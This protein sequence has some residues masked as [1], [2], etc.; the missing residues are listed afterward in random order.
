MG[1]NQNTISNAAFIEAFENGMTLRE[2][3]AHFHISLSTVQNYT[4][5]LGLKGQRKMGFQPSNFDTEL[6]IKLWNSN[7]SYRQIT[8]EVG[9][10][11]G[12]ITR[13][14]HQYNLPDREIV[15][16]DIDPEKFKKLYLS[17]MR[18]EDIADEFYISESYVRIL[19]DKFGLPTR[20]RYSRKKQEPAEKTG[21][22]LNRFVVPPTLRQLEKQKLQVEVAK[23]ERDYKIYKRDCGYMALQEENQFGD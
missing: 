8:K 15:K 22:T 20:S 7:T 23:A 9:C 2:L 19:K 5:K 11:Q 17:G 1:K 10:S 21:N 16:K 6:F 4:V 13:L 12:V 18:Y 14:R 3:A